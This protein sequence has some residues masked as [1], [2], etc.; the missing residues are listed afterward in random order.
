ME[1][2]GEIIGRRIKTVREQN[3]L[4]QAEFAKE[5]SVTPSAI[6]QYERFTRTPAIDI[7][8]RIVT[9]FG[10]SADYL[11]GCA[12]VPQPLIEGEGRDLLVSFGQLSPRDRALVVILVKAMLDCA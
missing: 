1:T 11:L 4:T 7:V 3:K 6:T 10:V 12:D 2:L 5:I 8:L 9:K